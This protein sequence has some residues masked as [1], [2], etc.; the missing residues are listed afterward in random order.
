MNASYELWLDFA[1][2]GDFIYFDPPYIPISDSANFTS[3]T[4]SK[5]SIKNHYRLHKVFKILDR[6]GCKVMLSNAYSDFILDTYSEFSLNI[7]KARR[8]INSDSSK[9]GVINELLITNY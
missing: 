4:K 2:E 7:L 1:D 6:R 5:F 8:V 9:R 3:Y